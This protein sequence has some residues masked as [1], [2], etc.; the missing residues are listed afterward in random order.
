[1]RERTCVCVWLALRRTF[2]F[3]YAFNYLNTSKQ[4]FFF[5]FIRFAQTAQ[6]L[7]INWPVATMPSC[8]NAVRMEII[9]RYDAQTLCE[10]FILDGRKYKK[11]EEKR[12]GNANWLFRTFLFA[13]FAYFFVSSASSPHS[14]LVFLSTFISRRRC[15]SKNGYW[16]MNFGD[17]RRSSVAGV[18]VSVWTTMEIK[19]DEKWVAM[20]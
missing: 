11:K 10:F 18:I 17:G 7:V 19:S 14:F 8:P 16:W 13:H 6:L 5:F 2:L 12:I 15:S 20:K 9:R 4:L 1:M 3:F